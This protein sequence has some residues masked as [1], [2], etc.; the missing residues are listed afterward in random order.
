MPPQPEPEDQSDGAGAAGSKFTEMFAGCSDGGNLDWDSSSDSDEDS[1]DDSAYSSDESDDGAKYDNS[2]H[3]ETGDDVV[4]L[5]L[6]ED[7]LAQLR[8]R[9]A[10]R[11]DAASTGSWLTAELGR[12]HTEVELSMQAPGVVPSEKT[13]AE[14]STAPSAEESREGG[15]AGRPGPRPSFH[16]SRPGEDTSRGRPSSCSAAPSQSVLL[17]QTQLIP[18]RSPKNVALP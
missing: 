7:H 16:A 17:L 14:T 9:L 2:Q 18:G 13:M 1:D 6:L 11:A 4:E 3:A 5:S 8:R 10:S 12:R 15:R